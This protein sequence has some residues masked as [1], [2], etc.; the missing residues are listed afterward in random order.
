MTQQLPKMAARS[1]DSRVRR[2]R[3]ATLSLMCGVVWPLTI[4]V[5]ALFNLLT[6][7]PKLP[8]PTLPD[9]L[10]L[11]L[12]AGFA[13]LPPIGIIAGAIG[14]Y[15]AHAQPALRHSRWQAITGLVLGCLWLVGIFVFS[16]AGLALRGWIAVRCR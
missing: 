14:L 8:G 15:R 1:G 10:V 7:G 11:A 5:P 3:T 2:N 4:L 12:Q 9:P 16:F 13:V 6:G